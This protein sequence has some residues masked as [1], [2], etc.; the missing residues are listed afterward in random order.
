[1]QY[2]NLIHQPTKK[3]RKPAFQCE[4]C[5]KKL[6]TKMS[7]VEHM[8]KHENKIFN[9]PECGKGL[10]T[11]NGLKNHL[12]NHEITK[13]EP[14]FPCSMCPK[15]FYRE[16]RANIHMR[17]HTGEKPFSCQYCTLTFT[18]RTDHRRHEWQ[19]TG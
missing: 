9:C 15:K 19:H 18:D 17:I 7:G 13:Q 2:H 5:G 14:T 1:M 3:V 11:E 8:K 6:T 4:I 16:D 12:R 10:H